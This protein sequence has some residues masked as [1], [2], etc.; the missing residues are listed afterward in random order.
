MMNE[1]QENGREAGENGGRAFSIFVGRDFR[2]GLERRYTFQGRPGVSEYVGSR[3]LG[4]SE[5]EYE[6]LNGE[7]SKDAGYKL[8]QEM[9]KLGLNRYEIVN[10]RK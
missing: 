9:R 10:G 7:D 5:Y 3:S 4:S 8:G 6:H 1:K 2:E